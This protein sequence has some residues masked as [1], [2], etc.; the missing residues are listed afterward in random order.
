MT[1]QFS[2]SPVDV[3]HL[4]VIRD[5]VEHLMRMASDRYGAHAERLLDVAP[6]DHAGARPYFPPSVEVVTFDIDPSSGADVIGDL[7]A[8]NELL[9]SGSFDVVVCTEVLEHVLRP[10]DAIDEIY[11]LLRPGGTL[12]ASSPFNFRIHGPLPDCWR[13]TEYGWRALLRDF[14]TV[15]IIAK[16]SPGRALMPIQYLVMATKPLDR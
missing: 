4:Q 1:D 10:F 2:I 7:C 9:A 15:E 16:E 8:T 13:F 14:D 12:V 6:Q 11:R 5:G 3:E